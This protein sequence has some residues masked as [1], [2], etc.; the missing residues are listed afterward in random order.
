MRCILHIGSEKTGST[1]I[2][3]AA[4]RQRK[5][6][7]KRGIRLSDAAGRLNNRKLAAFVQP[8]RA[9]NFH[10]ANGLMTEAARAAFFAGFEAEL[11]ADF[12]KAA[13][14]GAQG[15]LLTTEF[16]HSRLTTAASIRAL[17]RLLEP[18]FDSFIVIAYLREQSAL[19]RSAYSTRLRDGEVRT[20]SGFATEAR[21]GVHYYDPCVAM[22]LWREVFGAE[23][24]VIR[25]F[26]RD[27]LAGG[28]IVTDFF[29]ILAP[30]LDPSLLT[31]L[32]EDANRG[33]GNFGLAIARRINEALPPDASDPAERQLRSRLM[34][35][36]AL[37]DLGQAGGS[38]FPEAE[39]IHALFDAT[40]RTFAREFL[41]TDG[42][43]FRR[44]APFVAESAGPAGEM[45]AMLDGFTA[46]FLQEM[47]SE[48]EEP[49]PGLPQSG[50]ERGF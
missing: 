48:E 4:W 45:A 44:P 3:R 19:V 30:G 24:L 29:S 8:D 7:A 15:V 39:A 38:T 23:N 25:V 34:K 2:Q 5:L 13:A 18:H 43:P 12:D 6:L 42:N 10:Q 21:P 47:L 32:P 33:L 35:A 1:A 20:L 27:Q 14:A 41:G 37:S 11:A 16:F 36:L 31:R 26:E 17:R 50:G 9:D 22:P 49:A 40:N 46:S 28:D